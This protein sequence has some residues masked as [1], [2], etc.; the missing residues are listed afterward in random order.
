MCCG[1][2]HD[3]RGSLVRVFLS[4]HS[5]DRLSEVA[6][7][8]TQM[9]CDADFC[10]A[11]VLLAPCSR[12]ERV[13]RRVMVWQLPSSAL[14]DSYYASANE[15]GVPNIVPTALGQ[16][17]MTSQAFGRG[18]V[19]APVAWSPPAAFRDYMQDHDR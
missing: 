14:A 6:R 4:D 2:T 3:R 5:D 8:Q 17:N 1:N 10:S 18:E 13:T 19:V 11:G 15:V 16:G 9:G 12:F 7:H